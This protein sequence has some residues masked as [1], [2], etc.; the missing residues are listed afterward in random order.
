M[1]TK[2][3][4]ASVLTFAAVSSVSASPFQDVQKPRNSHHVNAGAP[5]TT[6]RGGLTGAPSSTNPA[7]TAPNGLLQAPHAV[8]AN[9]GAPMLELPGS[10]RRR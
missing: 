1:L 2:I 7:A 6:A 10:V 4:I 9:G 8:P 3:A 5:I